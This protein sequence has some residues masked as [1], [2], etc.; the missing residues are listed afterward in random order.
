MKKLS[1][2]ARELF[3]AD[4]EKRDFPDLV[5][6]ETL[7][8]A[9][10]EWQASVEERLASIGLGMVPGTC[11]ETVIA[12][13]SLP[14]FDPAKC[15]VSAFGHVLKPLTDIEQQTAAPFRIEEPGPEPTEPA[16]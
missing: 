3:E 2:R 10:D 13:G 7:C 14:S 11:G 15:T 5:R 1:E 4:E 16:E 9:L 12:S 6:H 8:A